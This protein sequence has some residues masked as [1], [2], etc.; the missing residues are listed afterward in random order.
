MLGCP[1]G[2]RA[3]GP[4]LSSGASSR[5]SARATRNE[6]SFCE[7]ASTHFSH[8][9]SSRLSLRGNQVARSFPPLIRHMKEAWEKALERK[10]SDPSGA[11]TA[12]RSLVESA[13]KH[14][15]DDLQVDHDDSDKLPRLYSKI[16]DAMRLAPSQHTEKVFKQILGACRSAVDGL[17][18]MRNSLSHAHGKGSNGV[19]PEERHAELAVNLA[20]TLTTFLLRTWESRHRR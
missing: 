1:S 20:G 8:T 9:W 18:A 6:G 5:A 7:R 16:A 19:R 12:A 4:P 11:I 14:I 13:V 2:F 10:R 15:L 3:V 17:A